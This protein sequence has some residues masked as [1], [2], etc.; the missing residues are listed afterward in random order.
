MKKIKIFVDCHVFD[1]SF[2]G[3]RTYIQ[4]LYLELIKDKDKH[5]YLA[6]NDINELQEIFGNFENVTFLKY[7]SKN[8]FVRLVFEVPW[9]V[10]KNKIDFAHFQYRVSPLKLCKY[11]VTTHDVL[12]EDFPQ[13]FPKLNRLESF[14]FYKYSALISDI[15][16][17]VSEYSKTR[18][19]K[20]LNAKNVVVM[21]NGVADEF[22]KK[23]DKNEVQKNVLSQFGVADYVIYISRWEPRKNHHLILKAF[24]NLNLFENYKLVFIGNDTFNNKEYELL[25]NR[26]G[27]DIKQK[28]FTYKKLEFSKM[29]L[30][31]RGSKVSVYPSRAEGFG[32]PPLEAVAA[33]IP[34]I[35][36]NQTAMSDFHFFGQFLFDPNLQDDFERCLKRVLVNQDS[37]IER[38]IKYIKEHY[39]WFLSAEIFRNA[40]TEHIKTNYS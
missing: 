39:N 4:G 10:Y 22:F 33:S 16:F 2:Q 35:C 7:H 9:F 30:L 23:Y 31:L 12:F 27:E 13:D 5:F 25:Y 21:P 18:I 8:A 15:I 19:E 28:I 34:T 37:E 17:T 6:A 29:L 40:I 38:K 1:N 14:L 36:S 32:I 20:H 3:T 11:I 24:I 26:L